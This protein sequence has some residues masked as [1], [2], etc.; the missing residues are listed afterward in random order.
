MDKRGGVHHFDNRAE[1]DSAVADVALRLGREQQQRRPDALAAAFAQ[2]LG[3]FGD[4]LDGGDG[5]I[6]ELAFVLINS[7][8]NS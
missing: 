4:G 2:I 5:V 7:T 1:T 3:D 8:G 6:A